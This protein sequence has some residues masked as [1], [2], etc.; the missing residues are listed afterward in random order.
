MTYSA[1]AFHFESAV[2]HIVDDLLD[3]LSLYR[4]I[5]IVHDT[6]MEVSVADMSE[7]ASKQPQI[8]KLL[9]RDV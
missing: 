8:V 7:N 5:P 6:R 9:L 4:V 1:R 3:T 2:N